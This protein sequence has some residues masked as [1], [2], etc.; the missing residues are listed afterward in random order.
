VLAATVDT[1]IASHLGSG[2]RTTTRADAVVSSSRPGLPARPGDLVTLIAGAGSLEPSQKWWWAATGD[3]PLDPQAQ[4][5]RWYVNCSGLEPALAAVPLL[6]GLLNELGCDAL[7]K[8][9]PTDALFDRR[10]ALLVYLPREASAGAETALPRIG[11]QLKQWLQPEVPP[12][13][14][15]LMPGLATAHDPGGAVSY[16]QLRCAQL[17]AVAACTNVE[18]S[19]N[20]LAARLAAVGI[21]PHHPET[22]SA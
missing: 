14:R 16:G 22:V 4:L 1:I 7:L 8:C 11:H 20:E 5:N 2:D 13:T 10:D 17:A 19:D 3:R 21:D 12:L 18:C 6:L 9:P 15:Q